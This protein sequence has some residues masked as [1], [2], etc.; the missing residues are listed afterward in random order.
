[1]LAAFDPLQLL[2]PQ[3]PNLFQMTL[4]KLFQLTGTLLS[5]TDEDAILVAAQSWMCSHES[6]LQARS[7]NQHLTPNASLFN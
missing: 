6:N 7:T 5:E 1:M 2:M 4:C 3:L